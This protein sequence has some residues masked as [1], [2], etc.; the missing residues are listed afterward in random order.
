MRGGRHVGERKG[1]C[2]VIGGRVRD[3]ECEGMGNSKDRS[4]RNSNININ[5]V[6]LHCIAILVAAH[7]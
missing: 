4:E 7:S 5:A 6:V 3:G 2:E 1:I